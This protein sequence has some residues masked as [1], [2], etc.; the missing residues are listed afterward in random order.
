MQSKR[1]RF[2]EMECGEPKKMKMVYG[3][4]NHLTRK[5]IVETESD[6][7]EAILLVKKLKITSVDSDDEV[8]ILK[9][10]NEKE[11]YKKLFFRN[12]VVKNIEWRISKYTKALMMTKRKCLWKRPNDIHFFMSTIEYIVENLENYFQ[13][14]SLEMICLRTLFQ[15]EIKKKWCRFLEPF[16]I[17]IKVLIELYQ[18]FTPKERLFGSEHFGAWKFQF[19]E[20]IGGQSSQNWIA[21]CKRM[22][23]AMTKKED[24]TF[25]FYV[26]SFKS[27]MS[28]FEVCSEIFENIE[29]FCELP[30]WH[31]RKFVDGFDDLYKQFVNDLNARKRLIMKMAYCRTCENHLQKLFQEKIQKGRK[32][33]W[34]EVANGEKNTSLTYAR[35]SFWESRKQKQNYTNLVTFDEAD[36]SNVTLKTYF[37]AKRDYVKDYEM[38]V[39]IKRFIH[40][41]GVLCK[42]FCAKQGR[43]RYQYH[44]CKVI[45][46]LINFGYPPE[47]KGLMEMKEY[48]EIEKCLRRGFGALKMFDFINERNYLHFKEIKYIVGQVNEHFSRGGFE[49]MFIDWKVV[50]FLR[51]ILR[52]E[53]EGFDDHEDEFDI[54]HD[55]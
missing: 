52:G 8:V 22:R 48:I 5:R 11:E 28:T 16:V 1:V 55:L 30:K 44:F 7:D 41:V 18:F 53:D 26:E 45:K 2:V 14:S 29:N 51:D 54:W 20:L 35:R 42:K 49:Y 15:N 33:L 13:G 12:V 47:R 3:N 27:L 39:I 17:G 31:N 19:D 24:I 9:K 34:D 21:L 4:G 32:L 10:P 6:D 23:M 25:F 50:D 40:D 38:V 46:A 36:I 43:G 37:I